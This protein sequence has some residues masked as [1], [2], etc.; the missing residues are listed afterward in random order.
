MKNYR[1]YNNRNPRDWTEY[2]V[3]HILYYN[4]RLGFLNRL[5]K[6]GFHDDL[7]MD[8]QNKGMIE[9]STKA[10]NNKPTYVY[11][12]TDYFIDT[13]KLLYKPTIWDDI[14]GFFHYFFA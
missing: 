6:L 14:K 4:S 3:M 7:I 2:D 10:I 9:I 1:E 11:K 5:V 12:T 8:L 13:F